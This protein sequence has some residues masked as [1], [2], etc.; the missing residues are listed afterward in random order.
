MTALQICDPP[1]HLGRSLRT[2][3]T[4]LMADVEYFWPALGR[5][6]IR[7][8]SEEP[9]VQLHKTQPWLMEPADQG[10]GPGALSRLVL[11]E[12]ARR[13]LRQLAGLRLPVRRLAVGQELDPD[14]PARWLLPGL[15]L[16]PHRCSE[17]LA[18]TLAGDAPT[19][20]GVAGQLDALHWALGG[21]SPGPRPAASARTR[22][23]F[24]V[25]AP[26][27]LAEGEP[28]VWYE[29]TSWRW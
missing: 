28:G 11:P 21:V 10:S 23:V 20:P 7:A 9:T 14:G 19:H 5:P 16:G 18:R 8:W 22:S 17:V 26:E 29:L 3:L 2:A 6:T 15:R 25:F 24:G 1:G 12:S 13:R 4:D 27:P